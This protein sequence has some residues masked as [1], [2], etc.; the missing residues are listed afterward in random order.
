M[1]AKEARQRSVAM[2][3]A[4]GL[5][6]RID[7]YPRQLSGG[8][9]QRVAI[10]RALV[11]RPKIVLADEPTAALDKASGREVVDLLQGLA[12]EENCAILL[13]THDN[14]SLDIA[15]RIL[16]L[17]DGKISSF[18]EGIAANSAQMVGAYTGIHRKGVLD[19]QLQ[20]MPDTQF[21]EVLGEATA[22]FETMRR[23]LATVHADATQALLDQVIRVSA[24][25]V[26]DLVQAERATVYLVDRAR[27]RLR[28][29]VADHEGDTPLEI[30][31]PIG[32]GI[33]GQVAATGDPMN[34]PDA[35]SHPAFDPEVDRRTGF[36]TRAVLCMPIFNP[37][38]EVIGV[39]QLLNK[40]G[41]PAFSVD[42]E[43]RFREFAKSLGVALETC[44][45]LMAS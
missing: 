18:T 10:A 42:D 16:T 3:E 40:R 21:A 44:S 27:G 15:D 20:E 24:T 38:N 4:V 30:E 43:R 19:R 11:R 34:I 36:R 22:Q 32:T 26:R 35:Y 31:L 41:A 7:H 9:K 29:K 33:A 39:A 28:S 37:R 13:V 1:T 23:S 6:H 25:R 45:R 14:R 2:L 5:G 12:R 17:E 8:Q